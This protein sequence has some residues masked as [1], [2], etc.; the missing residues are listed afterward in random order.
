MASNVSLED[1]ITAND[2]NIQLTLNNETGNFFIVSEK[3]DSYL[4]RGAFERLF[5]E[6]TNRWD[7]RFDS[8]IPFNTYFNISPTGKYISDLLIDYLNNIAINQLRR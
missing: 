5:N 2:F 8:Y 4:W 7:Y 3:N 6:K 1:A